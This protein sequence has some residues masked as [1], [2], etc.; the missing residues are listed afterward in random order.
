MRRQGPDP[1]VLRQVLRYEPE[2]GKLFWLA[3]P[4]AMFA[5]HSDFVRWNKRF[6]GKQ[7]F[8]APVGQE[9][10]GGRVLGAKYFSHRVAWAVHYGEWPASD[11]DHVNGQ[12]SDNRIAN[13]RLAT[14]AENARN[15][16]A[17]YNSPS[18]MVGV[19]RHTH[20]QKWRARITVGG[21]RISL[22]L[23]E[24]S[25]DAARARN[26]AAAALGDP[27]CRMAIIAEAP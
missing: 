14:R 15:R 11:V 9:Y 25:I 20:S 21:R 12:R 2:T 22:G 6:A 26:S 8:C 3:R 23:F 13:L 16:G 24:S 18:K 5:R 17:N 1:S 27:F 10:L 7:A 19:S 4:E